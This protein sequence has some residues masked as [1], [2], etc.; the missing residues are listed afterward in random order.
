V[1]DAGDWEV[2]T[3][4]CTKYTHS[5]FSRGLNEMVSGDTGLKM[6]WNQDTGEEI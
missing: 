4:K 6:D 1:S 5:K 2:E 3:R